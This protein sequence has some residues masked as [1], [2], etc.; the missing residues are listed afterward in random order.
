MMFQ[1]RAS[2]LSGR[3]CEHGDCRTATESALRWRRRRRIRTRDGGTEDGQDGGKLFD[4]NAFAL[5]HARWR[6]SSVWEGRWVNF[7]KEDKV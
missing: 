2:T 6:F 5:A 7:C 1:S 3:R 4:E